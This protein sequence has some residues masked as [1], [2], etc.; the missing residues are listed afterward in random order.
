MRIN[1]I[2]ISVLDILEISKKYNPDDYLYILQMDT[3]FFIVYEETFCELNKI[4]SGYLVYKTGR[5]GSFFSMDID[6]RSFSLDEKKSA[7][8]HYLGY[9]CNGPELIERRFSDLV[10]LRDNLEEIFS[11][12]FEEKD[13]F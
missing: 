5:Q 10:W 3:C 7:V 8:E 4:L 9:V 2:P 1:N 13:L 11:E 6:F 12:K